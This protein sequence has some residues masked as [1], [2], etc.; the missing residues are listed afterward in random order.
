MSRRGSAARAG[1]GAAGI[2]LLFALF[3]VVNYLGA[4]H[5][6]RGDWTR[7]HLFSL[8]QT[9]KKILG[10]LTKPVQIT[11]FMTRNSR[12]YQPVSEVLSRYRTASPKIEVEFLD[13]ERNPLRAEA[14]VK[15]FGIRQNT[16]VIRSGDRKKYVEEDKLA[17][18][19]FSG[20]QM[21]GTPQIKAF[22]GEEAFTSAIL[23]VTENNVSKIYFSTGHG[24]ADDR[25]PGA[26][27]G[28]RAG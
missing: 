12:L 22:K 13:P 23:D 26:R 9:T 20:A 15:Q 21:G 10:G 25:L 3:G 6:V 7:T 4:R 24:R 2:V 11:V 8:S 14:L 5:W 17:D 1:A 19:D 18:F 16:V 27:A 28:L